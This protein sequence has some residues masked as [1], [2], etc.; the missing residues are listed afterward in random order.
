MSSIHRDAR[1]KWFVL[2]SQLQQQ[3]L[4]YIRDR[5]ISSLRDFWSSRHFGQRYAEENFARC[6]LG[7]SGGKVPRPQQVKTTLVLHGAS[8]LL[9]RKPDIYLPHL[10][11][12]WLAVDGH[13]NHCVELEKTK[14]VPCPAVIS[15]SW[16]S[17]SPWWC[18]PEMSSSDTTDTSSALE[19]LRL[20]ETSTSLPLSRGQVSPLAVIAS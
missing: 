5:R 15:D 20:Y 18:G 16:A 17:C 10:Q 9:D 19:T 2:Q 14:P 6:L 7:Q 8:T 11:V 12:L 4:P 3:P 13:Q 1:T